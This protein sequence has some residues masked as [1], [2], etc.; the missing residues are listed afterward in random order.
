MD[1]RPG[2]LIVDDDAEIREQLKWALGSDYAVLEAE[3]RP[4]AV[5]LLQAEHP[6]LVTLDLGLSPSPDDATEGLAALEEFLAADRLAR[7]IVMTGNSDR[8][9]ALKAVQ[10]GAYDY[11]QKPVQLD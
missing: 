8:A 4:S 3:D 11:I 10:L 6:S 1:T 9:N 7:I 2:L 5:A